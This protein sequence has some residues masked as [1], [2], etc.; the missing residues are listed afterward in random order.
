M[1]FDRD[2]HRRASG[3]FLVGLGAPVTAAFLYP[4]T[5]LLSRRGR[6]PPVEW[7]TLTAPEVLV[8]AIGAGAGIALLIAGCI[9][10]NRR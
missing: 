10:L 6:P 3:Y 8:L 5:M 9:F 4:V 1:T 2:Q 7:E